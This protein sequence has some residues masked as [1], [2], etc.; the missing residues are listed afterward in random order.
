MIK[1]QDLNTVGVIPRVGARGVDIW[2]LFTA[3]DRGDAATVA[4]LLRRDRGLAT[5]HYHTDGIKI[6][7][8]KGHVDIVRLLLEHGASPSMSYDG[9]GYTGLRMAAERSHDRC[10][11]MLTSALQK[12]FRFEPSSERQDAIVEAF[13][14]GDVARAESLHAESPTAV[15]AAREDGV[16]P[17]HAAAREEDSRL[18]EWLLQHGADATALD[19]VGRS[20]LHVALFDRSNSALARLLLGDGDSTGIVTTQPWARLA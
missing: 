14:A 7:V 4:A 3:C 15:N 9:S 19:A 17:L 11:D 13:R 12:R 20:P 6:A 5:V 10:V 18:T 16:T 1:P 8:R 2:R